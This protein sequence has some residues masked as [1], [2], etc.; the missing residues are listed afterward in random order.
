ME[1]SLIHT[2]KNLR[3]NPRACVYTEPLWGLSMNL[4]LPYMSVFMLGIGLS[5]LQVGVTASVYMFSQMVF[6]LLSGVI[7]DKMGRRKSTVVFDMVSWAIPSLIWAFAQGFWFFAI[8]ALFNGLMRASIISWGC[9]MVEDAEKDKISHIYEWVFIGGNLSALF[10]PISSVLVSRLTLIPAVRILCVNAFIVMTV[11]TALLYR[12]STETRQGVIRMRE[13]QGHSVLSLLSG[14]KGV[15]RQAFQSRGMFFTILAYALI[16]IVS[17]I[18]STFWQIVVS[19]HIGVPDKWL[20]MFPMLRS[21]ISIA[22]FFVVISKINQSKLKLPVFAGYISSLI[23]CAVLILMPRNSAA[24]IW[25]IISIL[26][27]SLG[28]GILSTVRETLAVLHSDPQERSR[29]MAI[30]HTV[31]M[32][33]SMPFGYIGGYLSEVSRILPFMLNIGLLGM[34]MA[35][36][37]VYFRRE[38]ERI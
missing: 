35:V 29:I 16:E 9:L 23:S 30:L 36:S 8:A 4:C 2:L 1:N 26:F 6:S 22:L 33:V 31:V 34:G 25:L 13:T 24:Y 7:V 10:A 28:M 20:P 15:A 5:D 37:L 27:D 17:M 18:N 32:L 3:G 11:K 21:V 19:K 14:Y 12:F 38:P